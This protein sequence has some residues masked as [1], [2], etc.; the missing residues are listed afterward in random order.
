MNS[1]PAMHGPNAATG[2]ERATTVL[3]RFGV[4]LRHALRRA[5]AW[6]GEFTA[7]LP[8]P[9]FCKS[10]TM[11]A[12]I[13]VLAV[14]LFVYVGLAAMLYFTQRSMM[15]FPETIHTSPAE[16]GLPEAE[17]ISLTAADGVRIVG[18]HVA[19]RDGQP[20]ILYLHGNGG[21]LRYR[22]ER[23]HRLI[24]EG[25]G[26]VAIEYRGYGGSEGSPSEAGLFADAE[27]AYAF[28]ASRYRPDQLVLWGE[29]LG[30]GVAVYLAAEKPVG[31][32]ILEAPFTSTA[33]VAAQRYWFMP[34]RLL[35]KDQFRS[36]ERIANVS[37][38]VLILHGLNDRTVPYAMG[39]QMFDLAKGNKHIVRFIDGGHEDLDQYGALHAVG[40]FLAGDLDQPPAPPARH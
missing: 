20:V 16:A 32:V 37:A 13:A 36:D 23:F 28:A 27:A 38:P 35:M 1:S 9:A 30:T 25:V 4:Q 21:A 2:K 39:E 29:S 8:L 24:K 33:A 5:D 15:Y 34:V 12:L 11:T 40:R 26:L 3:R 17:E 7:R 14:L 18:W 31:R 6:R 19:P 22:V 10:R